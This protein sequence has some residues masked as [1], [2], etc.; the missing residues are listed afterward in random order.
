MEAA[1]FVASTGEVWH[2]ALLLPLLADHTEFD[3]RTVAEVALESLQRLTL[4][5]LPA[6]SEELRSWLGRHKPVSRRDLVARWV[7][8]RRAS[9]GAVPIGQA[10]RWIEALDAGDGATVLPL[11]DGYL[12]RA[13]FDVTAGR[14]SG[15]SGPV[16]MY[17][18]RIGTLLLGMGQ[19]SVP[20]ARD[21][22]ERCLD[23]RS[24]DVR[25]FGALALSAYD[26]RRAVEQLA[27]EAN[28]REAWRRRR[29]SE[30]LLQLGDKRG[31][32]ALLETL[33]SDQEA[34]RMFAC[35]D[36]RVYSQQPLP[37]DARATVPERAV[38]GAAWRVWWVANERTFRVRSWEATLD[39][40]VFP[41]ISPVSIS[42]QPVR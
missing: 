38:N 16:G 5:Q 35:R 3:G 24:P 33:D 21:R 39:L 23:V 27:K 2:A 22:L 13:D 37:C 20:G 28:G 19:R 29:A 12:R 31:I 6:D 26:R 32:P 40:Q 18:P 15:G 10:N 17:G 11:I 8:P 14:S 25:I 4:E 41:L 42:G 9:I 1:R 30:F 34:I 36:L 7:K